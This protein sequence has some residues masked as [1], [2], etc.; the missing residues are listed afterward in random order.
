MTN[1]DWANQSKNPVLLYTPHAAPMQ[2]AFYTGSMFPAEYKNDA[3]VAM[4]GS[5][6]RVPPSGYEVVRIRFDKA[7]NPVKFEPF[8]NGFLVKGGAPDG[9]DANFARLAGLAMLKDGSMLVAD[10]TNNIIYRVSY[11]PKALPPIMSREDISLNLPETANAKTTIQV[12]SSAFANMG[13]IPDKYSDYFDKISP[14]ISW[15]GI[16]NNAK[17]L[18]LMLEDPDAALKPV[19]HWI[20][21][22]IEP[23]VTSLPENIM[24]TENY[25]GAAQGGNITGKIGYYGPKPPPADLPHHYHFQIFALDTKLNLPGGFNRQ[26]LLDAMKGHVVAK[27]ETVGIYQR[28]PDVRQKQ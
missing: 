22:N 18:V 28:K 15:S 6:N 21:A 8:L 24:K 13:V 7:G 19:T 10:D 27:G 25:N 1:Q 16:P 20:I 11:K 3:F 4:R 23:N 17:S 26:S 12:K 9:K 14:E 2:M 5:W